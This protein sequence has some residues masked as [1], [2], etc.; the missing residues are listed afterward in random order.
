MTRLPTEESFGFISMAIP[1]ASEMKIPAW[2]C[3]LEKTSN[4]ILCGHCLWKDP[5]TIRKPWKT[6]HSCNFLPF[7]YLWIF[8]LIDLRSWST[9]IQGLD[10]HVARDLSRLD[11]FSDQSERVQRL[12]QQSGDAPFGLCTVQ[13]TSLQGELLKLLRFCLA[14]WFL[15]PF[16]PT[17]TTGMWSLCE[18]DLICA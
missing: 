14:P 16:S 18:E 10:E 3:H 17:S 11:P 5:E 15:V 6:W 13:T 2:R 9:D 4:K 12:S 1:V 8:K 7:G